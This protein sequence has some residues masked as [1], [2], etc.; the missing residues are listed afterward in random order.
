MENEGQ[1]QEVIKRWSDGEGWGQKEVPPGSTSEACWALG[2]HRLLSSG[3]T[4]P[5]SCFSCSQYEELQ[6]SAGR[7]GDDLRSTKM[8]ISELNRVIQRL[9]SEIDNLKKQ[10][11][12]S[13]QGPSHPCPCLWA[14]LACLHSVREA[15]P[16]G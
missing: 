8:E 3:L 10:V 15:S 16:D 9:R 1:S 6:R 12:L 11:G 14:D 5:A 7:H 2:I 13:P 4:I